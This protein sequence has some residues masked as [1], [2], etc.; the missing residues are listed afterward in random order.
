[1]DSHDLIK[2]MINNLINE[3]VEEA[4]LDLHQ[5]LTLKV[6]GLSKLDE[7]LNLSEAAEIADTH[8]QQEF[9]Q[10]MGDN[11]LFTSVAIVTDPKQ[12]VPFSKTTVQKFEEIKNSAAKWACLYVDQ[13]EDNSAWVPK[14]LVKPAPKELQGLITGDASSD[15][16]GKHYDEDDH[17]DFHKSVIA[18]INKLGGKISVSKL[19][20]YDSGLTI[21][22]LGD[23]SA[24]VIVTRND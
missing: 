4:N 19:R 18:A 14:S 8:E 24:L 16:F 12:I 7:Q 22:K 15:G 13:D 17:G 10:E 11:S 2:S 20:A 1:M 3:K 5:Y 21:V 9:A 23:G 6:R